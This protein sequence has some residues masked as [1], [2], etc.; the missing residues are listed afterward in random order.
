MAPEQPATVPFM[1]PTPRQPTPSLHGVRA[2]YLPGEDWPALLAWSA[3]DYLDALIQHAVCGERGA[4]P[5]QLSVAK[6]RL[7]QQSGAFVAL[8][9]QPDIRAIRCRPEHFGGA[10]V[11]TCERWIRDCAD[12][13]CFVCSLAVALDTFFLALGGH[14]ALRERLRGRRIGFAPSED[15]RAAIED[16]VNVLVAT[17]DSTP[18]FA[19]NAEWPPDECWP[20]EQD[21]RVVR[22]LALALTPSPPEKP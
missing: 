16:A 8:C 7:T 13:D 19:L 3:T 10:S 17:G 15:T 21:L 1:A 14:A 5:V 2:H 22:I 20:A 6:R 9:D 11:E 4:H 12:T 18:L